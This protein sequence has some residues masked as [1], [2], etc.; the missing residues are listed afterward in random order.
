MTM[1]FSALMKHFVICLYFYDNTW[2][3]FTLLVVISDIG[4]GVRSIET[5]L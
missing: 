1:Q 3:I 5:E 2:D 4:A